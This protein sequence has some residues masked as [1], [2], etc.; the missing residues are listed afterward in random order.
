MCGT[1]QDTNGNLLCLMSYGKLII[2]PFVAIGTRQILGHAL[3]LFSHF[4]TSSL[5]TDGFALPLLVFVQIFC[6][7]ENSP[8]ISYEK[9]LH[10]FAFSLETA[11]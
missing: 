5:Y 6:H 7:S 3:S 1:V 11:H 10:V 2:F 4:L 9:F 8:V